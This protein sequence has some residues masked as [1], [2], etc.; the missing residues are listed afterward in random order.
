MWAVSAVWPCSDTN[1]YWFCNDA[2][3]LSWLLTYET[4]G[5]SLGDEEKMLFIRIK[6]KL[7]L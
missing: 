1:I 5:E 7:L 4:L 3:R 2:Q 6:F